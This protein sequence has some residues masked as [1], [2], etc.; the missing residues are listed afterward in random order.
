MKRIALCSALLLCSA[1][2]AF[3]AEYPAALEGAGY[4]PTEWQV[5]LAWQES[6]DSG[7]LLSGYHLQSLVS[8]NTQD[9]YL[10]GQGN[11]LSESALQALDVPPKRWDEPPVTVTPE[12]K[13]GF[14]KAKAANKP[15]PW[16]NLS[17]ARRVETVLTAPPETTEPKTAE[18]D[19]AAKGLTRYG[20][21]MDLP[22][23]LSVQGNAA[24]LGEW[25]DL[26]DGRRA[27]SAT[28]RVL[29]A[30]GLR[31]HLATLSLPAG[32]ELVAYN[33]DAPDQ[34]ETVTASGWGPS[35]FNEAVTLE[36][37]LPAGVSAD[38]V[39][40]SVDRIGWMYQL[41]YEKTT[42]GSCNINI[43]CRAD[44]LTVAMAVGRLAKANS[45]GLWACTGALVADTVADSQIP[46]FLTANHCV[47]DQSEANSIEVYWLYQSETCDAV[48]PTMDKVPHTT[49]G[50]SFLAG[51]SNESGTD[52]ALLRLNNTPPDGLTY[53]GY[54]TDPAAVGTEVT[55]IHQPEGQAKRISFGTIT[56]TG[57]PSNN[58]TRLKP[59]DRFHEI[60]WQEGTTEPGSSGCPLFIRAN[61]LIIGQLYGGY[62][63]CGAPNEPDYFGRFDVTYPIIQKWLS[64]STSTE[65]E[66]T[67]EGE[68]GNSQNGCQWFKAANP[69][70][71]AAVAALV[72]V[73]ML[74]GL[75]G[76]G[77]KP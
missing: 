5:L 9:V 63:S 33:P 39:A 68:S 65:G 8:G 1:S 75:L 34:L 41:P 66:T 27:W 18:E 23:T 12:I 77:P 22:V 54:S 67:T 43:A 24:A 31:L 28:I 25:H 70:N 20:S 48:P 30:V 58:G 49:G 38:L 61:P 60:H 40:L 16:L 53:A 46:Y 15:T 42:V 73:L 10:D 32:A 21:V 59:I 64:P 57:S 69:A 13:P 50:A 76:R 7:T 44:W 29:G 11:L 62:A 51:A 17:D 36:C 72:G 55:A 19:P 4:P 56:D 37:R 3:A 6:T 71:A 52:F 14:P 35:C 2:F 45:D 74:A 47:S 26:S